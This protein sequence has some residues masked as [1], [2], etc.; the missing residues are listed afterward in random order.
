MLA[1]NINDTN[2]EKRCQDYAK[3]HKQS[4]ETIAKDAITSWL[5]KLK[6]N[7]RFEYTTK[8]PTKYTR[9]ISSDR[10][11]FLCDETALMHIIEILI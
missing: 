1:I 5:D 6:N 8:D 11:E 7:N 9:N 2:I 10:D 4:L 3:E